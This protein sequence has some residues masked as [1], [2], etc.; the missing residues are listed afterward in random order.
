MA[1]SVD[2]LEE[3]SLR[4]LTK[5]LPEEAARGRVGALQAHTVRV[6]GRRRTPEVDG[7]LPAGVAAAARNRR[8]RAVAYSDHA[9][10]ATERRVEPYRLVNW[11][12]RWYLVAFDLERDDWRTFQC[13][14]MS[15]TRSVGHRFRLRELPGGGHRGVRRRQDPPGPVKVTGRV[16]AHAPAFLRR[17][18]DGPVD[19]GMDQAGGRGPAAGCR[20]GTAAR[21]TSP[22][23]SA[24]SRCDF[25]VEDS[26][27]LAAAVQRMAERYARAAD[28][29]AGW[30]CGT[31]WAGRPRRGVGYRPPLPTRDRP[32][33][34]PHPPPSTQPLTLRL[35]P[36][37][38]EP[39]P[40]GAFVVLGRLSQSGACT[41]ERGTA[42][43]AKRRRWSVTGAT[44]TLQRNGFAAR[45]RDHRGSRSRRR[46]A[47]RTCGPFRRGPCGVCCAYVVR[48]SPTGMTGMPVSRA[49]PL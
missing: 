47:R 1:G 37:P 45:S 32:S 21:R 10:S 2:G 39:G 20:S 29:S 7:K 33:P 27:D 11:G 18:A 3:T 40:C 17:G 6:T 8:G 30:G 23:G 4:A 14:R 49:V 46:S 44:R 48:A 13:D 43:D 26:P 41:P 38:R 15:Q 19:A 16:V 12:M 24:S 35:R 25:E 22:S 42:L 36:P 9:G 34:L 31:A 5:L 28:P